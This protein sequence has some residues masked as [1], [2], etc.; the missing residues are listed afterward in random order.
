MDEEE[1]AEYEPG[2]ADV[3]MI[4][5]VHPPAPASTVKSEGAAPLPRRAPA[6]KNKGAQKYDRTGEYRSG[7]TVPSPTKY[8]DQSTEG[9]PIE[10]GSDD[11][12]KDGEVDAR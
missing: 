12:D 5:G 1:E 2:G 6:E 3:D 10:I 4:N 7:P 11:S 9:S 8:T